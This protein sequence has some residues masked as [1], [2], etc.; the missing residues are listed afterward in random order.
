MILSLHSPNKHP[1]SP[2]K[3]LNIWADR[4]D[5]IA[6]VATSWQLPVRGNPMYQLTTKL[7]RL[8]IDLKLFHRQ[9]TSNITDRVANAKAEW[10]ASQI[11]LD[12]NPALE[13]AISNERAL[14]IHYQHLCK[15]EESYF[16][17]KSR[18]QWMHLGDRN[19]SFFHKSL[20]TARSGT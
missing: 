10:D 17:Q 4:S 18:V 16:K 11:H 7:R 1:H 8:K 13:A 9:N 6:T 14:T 3:F 19:T 2:F 5:F 15:D 12:R 20:V